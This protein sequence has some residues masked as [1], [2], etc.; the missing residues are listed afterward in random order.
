M[1]NTPIKRRALWAGINEIRPLSTT[2]DWL[3]IGDFNEIRHPSEREGRGVSDRSGADEFEV[4][5]SGFT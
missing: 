5:I 1:G 3:L 4:T 2:N